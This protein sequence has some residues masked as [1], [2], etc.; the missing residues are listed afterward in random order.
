MQGATA[1]RPKPLMGIADVE[2]RR[3]GVPRTQ[4]STKRFTIV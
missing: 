3:L 1:G 4:I 2:L